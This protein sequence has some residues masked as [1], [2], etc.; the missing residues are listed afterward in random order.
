MFALCHFLQNPVSSH[1][2]CLGQLG[3][4]LHGHALGVLLPGWRHR[5]RQLG[6]SCDSSLGCLPPLDGQA[7]AR[8]H[9]LPG[10]LARRLPRVQTKMAMGDD[11]DATAKDAGD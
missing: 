4:L 2:S 1:D 7:K 5:R 11:G 6:R 9:M 3:L 10:Q 8:Q